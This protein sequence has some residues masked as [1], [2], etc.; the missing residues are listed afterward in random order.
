MTQE[1]RNI[2][3]LTSLAWRYLEWQIIYVHSVQLTP[4]LKTGTEWKSGWVCRQLSGRWWAADPVACQTM[5][6]HGSCDKIIHGKGMGSMGR[7][8]SSCDGKAI[9]YHQWPGTHHHMIHLL[10]F[11]SQHAQATFSH[12]P[13]T[14]LPTK[15]PFALMHS[16]QLLT[17]HVSGH[18][19]YFC[20]TSALQ[21]IP[22]LMLYMSSNIDLLNFCSH[23]GGAW[24]KG[25]KRIRNDG[26][27]LAQKHPERKKMERSLEDF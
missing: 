17:I 24:G 3:Q 1:D 5:L 13:L 9:W 6:C 7:M 8:T 26:R 20:M 27:A 22:L 19:H 14:Q 18:W 15:C 2:L 10:S 12:P 4:N 25:W 23:K 11:I 16:P 21:V